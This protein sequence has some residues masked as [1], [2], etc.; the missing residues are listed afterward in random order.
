[1]LFLLVPRFLL[2]GAEELQKKEKEIFV[3][4]IHS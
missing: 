2:G 4:Q 3:H 1:M